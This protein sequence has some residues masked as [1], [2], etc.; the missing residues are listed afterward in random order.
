MTAFV[1]ALVQVGF[2]RIEHARPPG[3]GLGQQFLD[4]AGAGEAPHRLLRQT[5]LAHD[6]LDAFALLAERVN[7]GVA[8][9][10]ADHQGPFLGPL[11]GHLRGDL[12]KVSL[13]LWL[14]FGL[15]SSLLY[16]AGAVP[17]HRLLHVLAEIAPQMPPVGD[18]DRVGRAGGRSVCVGA[19]TVS[20][21]HLHTRVLVQPACEGAGF[22]VRQQVDRSVGAYV[23]EHGAVPVTA[24]QREIVH[25]EHRDLPGLRIRYRADRPQHRAASP[26]HSQPFGKPGACPA[27]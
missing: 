23:D 1:P 14:D 27:G 2:V 25:A 19:G 5:Q 8:L 12:L 9:S 26:R 13:L 10:G 24:P 3:Q 16:E 11:G 6:R 18:L 21:D 17:G 15:G 4:A 22:T 7:R 20:A